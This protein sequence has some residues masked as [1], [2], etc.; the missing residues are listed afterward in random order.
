MRQLYCE[1][2]APGYGMTTEDMYP[3]GV[4]LF[5]GTG[6]LDLTYEDKLVFDPHSGPVG[7]F[8]TGADGMAY[9]D[10]ENKRLFT[11]GWPAVVY[12]LSVLYPD[13]E[14]ATNGIGTE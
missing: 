2:T 1:E 7:I 5:H 13:G 6:I 4:R 9:W 3:I 12:D 10:E 11:P 14:T 8:R